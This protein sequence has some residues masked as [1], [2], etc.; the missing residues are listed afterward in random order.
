MTNFRIS[1]KYLVKNYLKHIIFRTEKR[2]ED[3]VI[4][5]EEQFYYK[6]DY[7]SKTS[8]KHELTNKTKTVS[9]FKNSVTRKKRSFKDK[10]AM[11]E[12]LE[13]TVN[14]TVAAFINKYEKIS[15]AF[16]WIFFLLSFFWAWL[17][18]YK[19]LF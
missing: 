5:L 4:Y 17:Y 10:A 11:E 2:I 7:S 14:G 6:V 8:Y 3:S 9:L 12:E 13:K 16:S 1:Q 15:F 19:D 18:Q